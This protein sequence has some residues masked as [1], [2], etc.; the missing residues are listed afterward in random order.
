MPIQTPECVPKGIIT[1]GDGKGDSN[2]MFTVSHF[3]KYDE[4]LISH[5]LILLGAIN[6]LNV[7]I[8]DWLLTLLN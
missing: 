1:K 2:K 3:E 6:T 4:K 5:E 7:L 8:Y